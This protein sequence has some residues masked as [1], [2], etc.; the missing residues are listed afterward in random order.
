MDKLQRDVEELGLG[1]IVFADW[2][3]VPSMVK[4]RFFDD[5]TRSWWTPATGGANIPALNDLLAPFGIA[6]GDTILSGLFS[7]AGERATYASGT[8]IR[9]FPAG[10]YVHRFLFADQAGTA[11]GG[12]VASRSGSVRPPQAESPILGLT[13]A[14]NGRIAVFGDSNCIDSSHLVAHCYWLVMKLLDFT[15]LDKRDPVLF[16]AANE[17]SS[18]LG[19]ANTPLPRLRDD[20]NFTEY[21]S[22][23]GQPGP[24]CGIECSQ[25]ELHGTAGMVHPDF[26]AGKR[27]RTVDKQAEEAAALLRGGLGTSETSATGGGS[28]GESLSG[29]GGKPSQGVASQGGEDQDT[30]AAANNKAEG[31]GQSQHTQ[32]QQ[33]QQ[34]QQQELVV[35]VQQ[36]Q[37]QQQSHADSS[38]QNEQVEGTNARQ[39]TVT[40]LSFSSSI[41]LSIPP[42]TPFADAQTNAAQLER[43]QHSDQSDEQQK[44]ARVERSAVA[45]ELQSDKETN[46][47]VSDVQTSRGDNQIGLTN[48]TDVSLEQGSTKGHGVLSNRLSD[49]SVGQRQA[50]RLENHGDSSERVVNG[51]EQGGGSGSTVR[52]GAG[53]EQEGSG[54]ADSKGRRWGGA[55]DEGDKTK[56]RAEGLLFGWGEQRPRF[57]EELDASLVAHRWLLPIILCLAACAFCWSLWRV[58]QHGGVRRRR[59]PARKAGLHANRSSPLI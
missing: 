2:Y 41:V 7:I 42:P 31:V 44:G 22:V 24:V 18:P 25:K 33:Q 40:A 51:N 59:R 14:A 38:I 21:S 13:P 37:N 56:R 32:E 30:A 11:E 34:K 12:I 54:K 8:D 29:E 9:R 19:N 4:M 5:N 23:L 3:H 16:A 35:P 52:G 43:L 6:F 46:S 48:D 26:R 57:T 27:K 17:L 1:L 20:I 47:I 15:A 49:G 36:Q 39:E 10:G 45:T 53:R 58:H 28:S 55:R 50:E